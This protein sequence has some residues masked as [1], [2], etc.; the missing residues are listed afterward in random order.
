MDCVSGMEVAEC[1]DIFG[2]GSAKAKNAVPQLIRDLYIAIL[3]A[4]DH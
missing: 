1:D 4:N 2:V 3:C